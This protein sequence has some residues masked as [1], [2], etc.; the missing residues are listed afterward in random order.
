MGEKINDNGDFVWFCPVNFFLRLVL[1][2]VNPFLSTFSLQQQ[3]SIFL[4]ISCLRWS[5]NYMPKLSQFF[6]PRVIKYMHRTH[7]ILLIYFFS[8]IEIDFIP[9][10][11]Q[12]FFIIFLQ[13]AVKKTQQVTMQFGSLQQEILF[14]FFLLAPWIMWIVKYFYLLLLGLQLSPTAV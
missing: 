5:Q 2:I 1:R 4:Q 6:L 9:I 11:V 7:V 3:S 13:P 8:A 10:L 12:N 14:F